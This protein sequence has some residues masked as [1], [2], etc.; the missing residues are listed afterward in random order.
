MKLLKT[1]EKE[2]ILDLLYSLAKDI[3]SKRKEIAK[4]FEEKVKEQLNDLGMKNSKFKVDFSM[5]PARDDVENYL[6]NTGF[7]E[8]KFMFS[9]NAGQSLK[10]LSEIISGGEASRFML[11]LKNILWS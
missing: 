2:E 6:T 3:N 5:L 10:P 7:D 9:A 8:V 1:K 11:G 4:I